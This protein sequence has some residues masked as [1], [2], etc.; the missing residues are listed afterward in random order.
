[1]VTVKSDDMAVRARMYEKIVKGQS[2][3]EPGIPE[4]FRVMTKE[5]KSL[6]LNI[7]LL[8]E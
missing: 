7:E 6:G 5:L 8:E 3:L 1:M 2:V 4:S